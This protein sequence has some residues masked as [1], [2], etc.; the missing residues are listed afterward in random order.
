MTGGGAKGLYEAGVIHALHISGMEFDV[1]TGSSIG[2]LNSVFFAEYLFLKR[3]LPDDVRSDPEKAVEAMDRLIRKFHH[4]WLTLPGIQ[5]IDDSETGPLGKLKNDLL[6]FNLSIP[7][8]TTLGWWGTDPHRGIVPSLDVVE[9]G[10]KLVKELVERLGG[11]GELLRIY[12]EHRQD[13]VREALRTYLARF[14]MDRSIVP[15]EDDQKLKDVFTAPVTPLKPEHLTGNV[16]ETPPEGESGLV[17]PDRTMRDYYQAG[18][19]VRLTRANYRTGRLEISGYLSQADFI[20]WLDR[21]A[22]RLQSG[23]PDKIPLGSFRLQMPGNANAINAG[24]A[25]GR[26]PGVFAAYPITSIYPSTDPENEPLYDMLANWMNG[27][28]IQVAMKEGLQEV[29]QEDEKVKAKLENKFESWQTSKV[30][31]SFFANHEDAYVDGGAI[32]NTPSNSVV[33]AVREWVDREGLS[34]RKVVLETIVVFLHKEPKVDQETAASPATFEVVGRTLEIQGAAKLA[35]NSGTV[36]AI[37]YFGGQG[38][39][40]GQALLALLE[41]LEAVEP[42]DGKPPDGLEEAVRESASQRGLRGFLDSNSEGILKRLEDWSKEIIDRKLPLHVD[43]IIIH[44]EEMPMST[45]QFTERLG[46]RKE[47]AIDMLT[48]GCYN[49]LWALRSHLEKSKKEDL[50]DFDQQVFALV[51]KWM[52]INEFPSNAKEQEE[53]R[54]K[55]NCQR[56]KCVYHADYCP[57]GAK[58]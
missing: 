38:E 6:K 2:A 18:I 24:L 43:E 9:A 10:I 12:K 1:I 23:D 58:T 26:F 42:G 30:M 8:V 34:K 41:G 29:H 15:D 4:A 31:E 36:D 27:Q 5:I 53:L 51:K 3:G 55:W 37:N 20:R 48:M 19:D 16:A 35:S 47:N 44:P 7:Q 14:D 32:D 28:L 46:Y 25:S 33:D 11:A 56:T 40:L 57:R 13:P 49:T 50:D 54:Q 52:G 21:Q 17:D 22:W 45:L 39:D